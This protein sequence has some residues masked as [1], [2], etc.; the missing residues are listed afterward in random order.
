M[1]AHSSAHSAPQINQI[2][3]MYNSSVVGDIRAARDDRSPRLEVA[4]LA[5][6]VDSTRLTTGARQSGTARRQVETTRLELDESERLPLP[7][8]DAAATVPV[9]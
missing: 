5:A 3:P 1:D 8:W 9:A 2:P 7:I 4:G 6:G